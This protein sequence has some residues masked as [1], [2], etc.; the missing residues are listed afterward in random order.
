MDAIIQ[1]FPPRKAFKE[2]RKELY[3]PESKLETVSMFA[4]AVKKIMAVHS[5]LGPLSMVADLEW[6]SHTHR[7]ASKQ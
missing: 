4:Y 5:Y 6:S 1:H 3:T 7:I 2:A